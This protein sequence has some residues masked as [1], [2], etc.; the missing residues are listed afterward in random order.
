MLAALGLVL[1][2]APR[3]VLGAVAVV[4]LLFGALLSYVAYKFMMLRKQVNDLAKSV[5]GSLYTGSFRGSKPD[6][7]IS[8]PESTKIVYH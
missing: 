6:I 2:L 3:L 1:L 5:E 4:L 8:D 7:D